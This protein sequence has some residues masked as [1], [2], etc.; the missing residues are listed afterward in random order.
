MDPD[1]GGVDPDPGG[2]DPAPQ[3]WFQALNYYFNYT[4]ESVQVHYFITL[5]YLG[6]QNILQITF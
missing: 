2:V 3:P 4:K 1:P 5:S 6:V